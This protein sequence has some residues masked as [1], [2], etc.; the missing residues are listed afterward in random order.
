M[1]MCVCTCLCAC[2]CQVCVASRYCTALMPEISFSC[3]MFLPQPPCLESV[4]TIQGPLLPLSPITNYSPSYGYNHSCLLY[5]HIHTGLRSVVCIE[6]SP[7]YLRCLQ[8]LAFLLAGIISLRCQHLHSSPSTGS[9][10]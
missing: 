6:P 9:H 10:G 7:A 5:T 3:I 2:I 8:F 4:V 1:C